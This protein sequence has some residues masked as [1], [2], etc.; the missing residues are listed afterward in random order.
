MDNKVSE[1]TAEFLLFL[2]K[3]NGM[4]AES[5]DLCENYQ[6]LVDGF[7]TEEQA[8]LSDIRN[9]YMSDCLLSME[10][11]GNPYN[12]LVKKVVF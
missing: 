2:F 6:G 8:R 5:I 9:Y 3:C 10:K 1:K 12:D 7:E 4:V 11:P